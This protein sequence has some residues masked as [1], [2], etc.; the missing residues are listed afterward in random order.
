MFFRTVLLSTF[1]FISALFA[2]PTHLPPLDLKSFAS[3]DVQAFLKE[4]KQN[5]DTIKKNVTHDILGRIKKTGLNT[6]KNTAYYVLRE[7]KKLNVYISPI[8]KNREIQ[9]ISGRYEINRKGEKMYWLDGKKISEEKYFS[10]VQQKRNEFIPEQLYQANLTASEIEDLMQG[11]E[12]VFID[13]VRKPIFDYYTDYTIIFNYS[14]TTSPAHNNSYKGQGIGVYFDDKGCS[15]PIGYNT[16]YYQLL[17]SCPNGIL[18]HPTANASIISK[19]APLA[20]IYAHDSADVGFFVNLNINAYIPNIEISS[21]PWHIHTNGLYSIDDILFDNFIYNNRIIS[22]VSAGNIKS[23]DTTILIGSPGIALNTITVGATDDPFNNNY[24]QSKWKNSNI[25]NQ[26]PEMSNYSQFYFPNINLS[27]WNGCVAGTSASVPYSS[28]IFADLLSQHAFLKRHPELAK[29]WV[30]SS[31]KIPIA[32]ASIYDTD[33]SSIAAKGMSKYSS[34]AWNHRV[35]YWQ[36]TNSC[37][38]DS[39][40][41]ITFSESDISS[42]VHYRIAIAW[43][44]SGT[45]AALH[46]SI[47]QDIDLQVW[48]NGVLLA[49]SNSLK[50]PFEVVDFTTTSNANLTIVIHRFANSGSDNVILGYTLWNDL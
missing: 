5:T 37:C 43:L 23:S 3:N 2:K 35:R 20:T 29:A 17:G 12:P 48:Q 6:E 21:H 1:L 30:I 49:N 47:S 7:Q 13:I 9:S 32:N 39:N 14:E 50:N 26:K 33:N 28:A 25:Q 16:S 11:P 19:T 8:R 41:K 42:G 15:D 31:E 40:N 34:L 4:Q 44:T 10:A 18:M 24:Y 36:G 38:F 22:F 46:H 45:Y 27:F